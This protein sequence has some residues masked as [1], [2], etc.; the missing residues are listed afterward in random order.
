MTPNPFAIVSLAMWVGL[1]LY[2]LVK[3]DGGPPLG[4]SA[5]LAFDFDYEH[6]PRTAYARVPYE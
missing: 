2:C 6:P 1:W 3:G 4:P 5:Q